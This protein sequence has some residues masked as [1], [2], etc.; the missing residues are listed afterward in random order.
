M[1]TQPFRGNLAE[2]LF[3]N[4]KNNPSA[5]AVIS[6]QNIP[7]HWTFEDLHQD[8]IK[9]ASFFLSKGIKKGDR[10]LLMVNPGYDLIV[11]CFAL[12][13]IG[14]IPIIIDP[15][16]G[17][18]S[19]LKCVRRSKPKVLL[20]VPLIGFISWFFRKTFSTIKIKL[21]LAKNF[22]S[23]IKNVPL[24]ENLKSEEA[25]DSDLA[26]IVFTSGSTG[27]P[28]GVRYLHRNFNA[29]IQ[30]LKDIFGIIE[31]EIDL[32]TLPVFSLFNPALG[33]TSVIP[34]M[35]PRKPAKAK[36][37]NILDA[38]NKYKTT[39][40]FC[41]PVIGSKIM[42]FCKKHNVKLTN[43]NRIMLAGAPSSPYL[44]SSLSS[45][46]PN[47]KVIVPYGATE[48]L[49]VSYS[50]HVT[51]KQLAKST[52]EG[53]GSNLGKPVQG[54]SILLFPIRNSPLPD[55]S[56]E[57][58][59]PIKEK[60]I[61]GE[62]CVSGDTVTDGYDNMPGATRDA[63][64][65]FNGKEYHRMGDLG[66]WDKDKNLRFMGRKAECVLTES[67]PLETER[68]EPIFNEI[69][70]VRRC[71]LIGIGH[72]NIKEPSL[73]VEIDKEMSITK[74]EVKEKILNLLKNDYSRFGITK[75]F[76]EKKLPV[77]ARHN[78]KI[79]RL[80]LSKKWTSIV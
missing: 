4:A 10:T 14:S 31:G 50:D 37:S 66:H 48:A 40:A 56:D 13:Y 69:K 3:K 32:V 18:F 78:A 60:F 75:V 58:I 21:L 17:L 11:Y 24:G 77:D 5:I 42:D 25:D 8:V 27:P 20:T 39:S 54:V 71:A 67:G 74:E 34:R 72:D 55:D 68:C 36:A 26:A 28:K 52:L 29:Q 35:N 79:H 9:C 19:L 64:F 44:I 49:P 1:P 30:V 2:H 76:F 45:H 59:K 61:T 62:I 7:C 16:M 80:S 53:E 73:V 23:Q 38:I 70:G 12:L 47:G 57:K 33:V 51:I 63:R 22:I 43:M 65:T 46:L 15:G 41:S 6:H